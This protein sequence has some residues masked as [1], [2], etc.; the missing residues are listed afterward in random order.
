MNT[1]IECKEFDKYVEA[2][3]SRFAAIMYVANVARHRRLA[4]HCCISEAQALSWVV[5]GVEPADIHLYYKARKRLKERKKT[6]VEDRLLYIDDVQV[7]CAVQHSIELSRNNNH[8]IYE[9]DNVT[10]SCRQARVRILCNMIW[11]ELMKLDI[12]DYIGKEILW[13]TK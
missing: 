1:Y 2:M 6:Y 9:Y 11:D 10:D 7:R 13:N 5:T 4:V 8:L 12:D 3:G